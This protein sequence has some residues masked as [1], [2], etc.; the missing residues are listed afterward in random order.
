MHEEQADH[1]RALV[2]YTAHADET[3][4][5]LSSLG[6]DGEYV[7]RVPARIADA[8]RNGVPPPAMILTDWIVQGELHWVHA[9]AESAKT[10]FALWAA[11]QL[12]TPGVRDGQD[13]GGYR[14]VY[15]D[16]ELGEARLAER[17]LSLGADPDIV[18]NHFAYFPFPGWKMTPDEVAEHQ[19]ILR[20]TSPALAIYDTATD[21]LS[22]AALDENSGKD[23]TSWVKAYPE[24]A[25]GLH[26][27]TLV[28]DHT[29][30]ESSGGKYAVG[31]RAKR[32][33]AKVQYRIETAAEFNR[34]TK[35][36]VTI[37]LT[38][39]TVGATIPKTR[40]ITVGGT[41][42]KWE[43]SLLPA[44]ATKNEKATRELQDKVAEKIREYGP[45][46]SQ[47]R[48]EKIVPGAAT[49]VREAAKSL[50]DTGLHGVEMRIGPKN[51]IL[52]SI[53]GHENGDEAEPP[54]S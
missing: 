32:A 25:R 44:A 52:Y 12:M 40:S 50:A 21:A 2:G 18:D 37:T 11:V 26:A 10:W 34:E 42:F 33:K 8:M 22:E 51:A 36:A 43:Q 3:H 38:K 6:F 41:P 13:H 53:R 35:G 31:S 24:Q 15:F 20:A 29:T 14:V 30:K 16:E 1:D 49:R 9:E 17:L 47:T 54:S 48:L 39:N 19:R 45:D 7:G 5:W 27:A 46:I 23:V 4:T 28:L